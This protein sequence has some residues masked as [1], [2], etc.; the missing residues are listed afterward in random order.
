MAMVKAFSYGSGSY[1]IASFLQHHRV[2]YFAVAYADEGVQLRKGGINAPVMVMNPEINSFEDLLRYQLEPEIFSMRILDAF[3]SFISPRKNVFNS[4]IHIKI[5]TG[6]NRLGFTPEEIPEVLER[7]KK[8]PWIKVASIF[9]H[10]VASDN[11][12]LKEFTSHQINLN[13]LVTNQSC[14]FAILPVFQIFLKRSS[15]W[16]ALESACMV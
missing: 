7:L 8:N 15:T 5:D 2:D 6:M 1:E 9:S 10:L 16:F 11:N 12:S 4:S 14:T 13:C 3:C